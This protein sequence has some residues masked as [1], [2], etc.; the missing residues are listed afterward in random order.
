[1]KKKIIFPMVLSLVLA[2]IVILV[3]RSGQIRE[4]PF[5]LEVMPDAAGGE[6]LHCWE[7]ED[8]TWYAFLP[9]YAAPEAVFFRMHTES[10]VYLDERLLTDGMDC[11]GIETDRPHTLTYT[12]FGRQERK[13]IVFLQGGGLPV[14]H[15]DTESGGMDYIHGRKGNAEA[16]SL[17]LYTAQ[18]Q[19][20]YSGKAKSISGRGNSTWQYEKKPYN[21][22]LEQAADLLQMGTA[23]K[24]VLLANAA[25][26]S[27]FRNKMVYDLAETLNLAFSPQCQWVE[28]YLNGEYAGVYLLSER[29][30]VHPQR[31]DI[32]ESGSFLV[33]SEI[34]SRLLEENY[35]YITT[36]SGQTLRIHYASEDAATAQIWQSVEN[37]ILAEDGRDPVTGKSWT[38]LIDLDSWV[39]KYLLE[40]VFGSTDACYISQFYY[41]DGGDP[42]G[43]VY[44]G[45]V[46]DFDNSVGNAWQTT[47]PRSFLGNR[48]LV[49]ADT[50]VALFSVLY[51]RD[52]FFNRMVQLYQQDLLPRIL[53]LLES[54]FS[55][56]TEILREAAEC[57]RVRWAKDTKTMDSE[58]AYITAYL[59]QRI[60]FL[61]DVWF[62]NGEYCIVR[63]DSGAA[64][65]NYA[66]YA[67]KPGDPLPELYMFTHP[68]DPPFVGWFYEDTGEP[69]DM[70]RPV[71]TDI[72][73]Y[74]KWVVQPGAGKYAAIIPLGIIALMGLLLLAADIKK[75]TGKRRHKE[76]T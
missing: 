8:G 67:V 26:P 7:D 71:N 3:S 56:Y 33:S 30:E 54:G 31:V 43:K 19:L 14:M 46:W 23:E 15:M 36:S 45:P 18:G 73:I 13:Q 12:V 48:P 44:A 1:M 42:S 24:W 51:Q 66:Y 69:V 68:D 21:L 16:G 58:T 55:E 2:V 64:G 34:E 32:A 11:A 40:E 17:R 9:G 72:R 50:G 70:T 27:H 52:V 75:T 57:D 53:T 35:P 49:K 61:S 47:N 63:A 41:R 59:E 10:P 60:E 37:A 65:V 25:D 4:I 20:T 38:E 39:K 62:N 74:G 76:T 6:Q 29:N 22:K 5:W 28:L